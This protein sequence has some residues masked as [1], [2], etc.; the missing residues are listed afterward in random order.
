MP[1]NPVTLQDL[2]PPITSDD[3]EGL[4]LQTLKGIGPVLQVGQGAGVVAVT[5]SPVANYDIV[6]TLTLGGAP[7]SA[8]FR[9]SLDNGLTTSGG[10]VVPL[11]GRYPIS[12]SGVTLVFSGTFVAGD[13][14]SA[15]TIYPPFQATDFISGS[16][17]LTFI[18]TESITEANLVGSD[19][20]AIVSGGFVDYASSAGAPNDWLTLLSSQ[21]Y[22]NDRF[23]PSI[24]QGTA[25]LALAS[26]AST[27]TF[28]TGALV[29]SNSLGV[30]SNVFQ[31]TN[32]SGFT[33]TPGSTLSIAVQGAGPG[34]AYNLS[35]GTVTSIITARAGLSCT[36]P[37]P[38][39]SSVTASGGATGTVSV[40]GTPNGNFSVVLNVLTTGA[41]GTATAQY[42]LDG[43]SNFSAPFT[44]PLGGSYPLPTIDGLGS[45]GLTLTLSGTFTA[46]DSYSFTSYASWIVVPGTDIESATSL[47]TRDKARWPTLGVS[48][49][50]PTLA[51]TLLVQSAP[52]GGSEVAK[53]LALPDL[54]IGGQLNITV[55]GPSGPVSTSAI[56]SITNFLVP[57]APLGTKVV[58]QNSLV[59]TISLVGTVYVVAA[60]LSAAQTAIEA[61]YLRL[62]A[63][64][65]IQGLVTFASIVSAIEDQSQSGVTNVHITTPA[66][67]TD[68]QLDANST[69][70]FDLTG[71]TYVLQ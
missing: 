36:N 30:G 42:S 13:T 14:Y 48:Q 68:T 47:Q 6:I 70:A 57:R 33:I 34:A 26:T 29:I 55:A 31:F 54:T 58:V 1:S 38:G 17:N 3:V 62:A 61:A 53:V 64:T 27:Q 69:V 16:A 20:P 19:I 52:S 37:S 35:N 32:V 39:T 43:G 5:G 63:D 59:Q 65:E 51:W 40:S 21:V 67:N 60:Q 7:G 24:M 66:P 12:G 23:D 15:Q 44:T 9:Y 46:A 25:V 11:V 4:L 2:L 49:A 45:T 41:L 28:I 10:I 71:L 22:G 8:V 18:K 50:L 56:S